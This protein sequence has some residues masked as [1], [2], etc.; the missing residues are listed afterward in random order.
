[1]SES[2]NRFTATIQLSKIPSVNE[3]LNLGRINGRCWV[4]LNSSIK[5]TKKLVESNL[6][7]QGIQDFFREHDSD[8]YIYEQEVWYVFKNRFWIRDTSNLI[9]YVEDGVRNAAGV[10]DAFNLSIK[11]RKVLNDKDKHEYI[12]F[13]IRAVPRDES[14]YILSA[15]A[16]GIDG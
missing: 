1:M 13:I 8:K 9:K 16:G 11:H 10:D 7:E 5:N 14:L 4:Y 6:K 2:K 3:A 15:L 12:I